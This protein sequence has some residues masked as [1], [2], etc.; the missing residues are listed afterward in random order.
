[1]KIRILS[2]GKF[3]NAGWV[4]TID[5]V[6]ELPM[7]NWFEF[8]KTIKVF[9]LFKLRIQFRVKLKEQTE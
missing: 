7:D 3:G 8:D 1:M 5:E 9:G 2:E 4:K 6:V